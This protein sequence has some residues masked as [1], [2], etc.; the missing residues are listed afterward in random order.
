MLMYMNKRKLFDLKFGERTEKVFLKYVNE[1]IFKDDNLKKGNNYS[2]YDFSNKNCFVELKAR[3]NNYKKYE[4]TMIGYNKLKIAENDE[5]DKKYIF[6]FL[7]TDGLY[8]WD[9]NM[10]EYQVKNGGRYDRGRPEFK[11]HSFIPI[12]F[13]KLVTEDINSNTEFQE[14][15][16]ESDSDNSSNLE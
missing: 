12:E 1:N 14:E 4:T 10:K 7:F 16:S 5:T 13:L 6:Y 8:K 15:E 11:L 2:I 9:F 3:T